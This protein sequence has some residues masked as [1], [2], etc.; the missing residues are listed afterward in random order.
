M[1]QIKDAK[2]DYSQNTKGFLA[3]TKGTFS[4]FSPAYVVSNEDLRWVCGV[5]AKNCENVLTV[6]G[7]GDQALFYKLNG[8]KN[9]D[10]FDISY[11]SKI[12]MDLKTSAIKNLNYKEYINLLSD[13][14]ANEPILSIPNIDKVLPSLPEDS[15]NFVNEMNGYKIFGKGSSPEAYKEYLLTEQEFLKTREHIA[16]NFNFIWTDLTNLS[17]LL[18]K[19]YDV[20]NLSNIVEYIKDINT[21]YKIFEN[22]GHYLNKNGTMIAHIGSAGIQMRKSSYDVAKEKFK[23]WANVDTKPKDYNNANSETMVIIQK[24]R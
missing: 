16:N 23:N 13:L 1:A 24:T 7:S 14:H 5:T 15:M 21:A 11:C 3:V 6:S 18:T 19:K 20:I 17:S 22:L 4:E 10:T 12:I 2:K 8:A 9:I